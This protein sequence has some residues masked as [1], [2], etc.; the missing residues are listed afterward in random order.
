MI[1]AKPQERTVLIGLAKGAKN[2]TPGTLFF[3][4]KCKWLTRSNWTIKIQRLK[5]A[6]WRLLHFVTAK[7]TIHDPPINP[8][9]SWGVLPG[10]RRLAPQDTS[11]IV[12]FNSCTKKNISILNTIKPAKIS[13]TNVSDQKCSQ[14][15][16]RAR[17]CKV[18][19]RD[20][21]S[22]GTSWPPI[23]AT[24]WGRTRHLLQSHQYGISFVFLKF[25]GYLIYPYSWICICG[26]KYIYI[27]VHIYIY[28]YVNNY[29]GIWPNYFN[30][31][32]VSLVS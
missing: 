18:P 4:K 29:I 8:K 23:F 1:V 12:V 5:I 10:G 7:G 9:E 3:T 28:R 6:S 13:A 30:S 2:G 15:P 26:Y 19:R 16:K 11:C 32:L 24:P 25:Y 31:Y 17:D 21:A 20:F 14:W 22:L 27:Y